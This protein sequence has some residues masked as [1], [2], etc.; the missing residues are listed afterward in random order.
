ML[1][2]SGKKRNVVTDALDG[3]GVERVGLSVDRLGARFSVR[4]EF[5]DHR[6]VVD[7]NLA[8]LEHTGIVTHR[9][10]IPFAF[11]GRA[12]ADQSPN[13]RCKITVRILRINAAFDRPAVELQIALFERKRLARRHADHLLDQIDTGNKFG[14]RVLDL[15]ARIHFQEIEAAVLAGDEL[16]GAGAVV[17]HGFG[18]CDRLF[19]HFCP[20]LGVQQRARRFLDD[21]LVA[22]LDRALAL[23]EINDV[24]MLVAQDLN[25]DVARIGDEFLDE[26][27]V[28]TETRFGF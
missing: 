18:E 23:A 3:K 15:K 28:V 12:I 19:A 26:D 8:A 22:A 17:T 24:A 6:I 25:F 1:H 2:D 20:G 21:F 27:A 10:A 11:G 13:R 9:H 16:H 4:D 7:R 14:H 5:R